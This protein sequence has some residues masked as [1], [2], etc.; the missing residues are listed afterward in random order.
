M[1]REAVGTVTSVSAAGV[2]WLSTFNEIVQIIAGV[3]AIAAGLITV[4]PWIKRKLK[5]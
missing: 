3:V 5:K 4:I 2:S 1:M